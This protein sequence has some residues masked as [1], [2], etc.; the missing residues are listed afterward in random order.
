MGGMGGADLGGLGAMMNDPEILEAMQD[1]DVQRAFAVSVASL[2][3][4]RRHRSFFSYLDFR[5]S[6]QIPRS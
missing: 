4:S 6:V 1:P 5:K 2:E 3:P